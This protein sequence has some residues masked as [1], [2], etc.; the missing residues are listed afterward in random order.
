MTELQELRRFLRVVY[1]RKSLYYSVLI[2]LFSVILTTLLA[3]YNHFLIPDLVIFR[4]IVGILLSLTIAVFLFWPL[5]YF[6]QA[7]WSRYYSLKQLAK[8]LKH[9]DDGRLNEITGLSNEALDLWAQNI[10]L[11]KVHH[12]IPRFKKELNR[13]IPLNLIGWT[14]TLLVAALIC[15]PKA[16]LNESKSEIING[17]FSRELTFL[18]RLDTIH[19]PF[20]EVLRLSNP[21][22][23][24]FYKGIETSEILIVNNESIDWELNGRFYKTQHIICDSIPQLTSWRAIVNPPKYLNLSSYK[25]QDTIKAFKGSNIRIEYQGVLKNKISVSR[26]TNGTSFIWNGELIELIT[27]YWNKTLPTILIEDLPPSITVVKN[28][29]DS[30][31]LFVKDDHG[32]SNI[33]LGGE[34]IISEGVNST[35]KLAWNTNVEL[36]IKA[37]DRNG[38]VCIREVR[39]PTLSAVQLLA[40][41]SDQTLKSSTAENIQKPLQKFRTKKKIKEESTED[42]GKELI[43]DKPYFETELSE[44]EP[45]DQLLER[46]DE[47][48]RMEEAIELLSKVDSLPNKELD[49]A[50]TTAAEALEELSYK[51]TQESADLIKKIEKKGQAREEQA[52][53]ASKKLKEFLSKNIAEVQEDNVSR[54]KRLL[55]SGWVVSVF[56][57]SLRDLSLAV[58]KARSQQLVLTNEAAIKDSLDLLLIHEPKLNQMLSEKR[59]DLDRALR[60]L[61]SKSSSGKE[62]KADIGYA[63]TALNDINQALYFI[64]ESEKSNLNQAKK[65]CK[66]GKPGSSGKPSSSGKGKEGKKSLPKP[67]KKPGG[68]VKGK[69]GE[70]NKGEKGT[71]PGTTGKPGEKELLKRIEAASEALGKLGQNAGINSEKLDRMKE[72][73]LFNNDKPSVDLNELEERLWRVEESVFNKKELGELRKSNSGDESTSHDGET[74]DFKVLKSK[75]TDLPLPVLKKL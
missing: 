64:L 11:K 50:L 74:I 26:E 23:T 55:K 36:T 37:T 17:T 59:A 21:E 48:W 57:E 2:L 7:F 3:V 60:S 42:L 15:S 25:T 38:G 28:S 45:L 70:P 75:E 4:K 6:L 40:T 43:K 10:V 13:N 63:V 72:E 14:I 31:V 49:S 39:K 33:E 18:N 56:Q 1:L 34:N 47:L 61:E 30:L 16:L 73:L 20:K 71:K 65:N 27:D 22:L 62:M 8:K 54:I 46:L 32:L 24:P 19:I 5:R 35:V 29:S 58:N 66:K 44:K 67:S 52:K 68:R 41:A 69:S 53:D 12:K 51:E 9:Y